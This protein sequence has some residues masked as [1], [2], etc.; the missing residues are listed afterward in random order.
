MQFQSSL[1]ILHYF[2]LASMVLFI[3]FHYFL[4]N[5]D[6]IYYIFSSIVR[7]IN[8]QNLLT[9]FVHFHVFCYFHMRIMQKRLSPGTVFS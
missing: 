5:F 3:H 9:F 7:K 6:K 2:T 4:H 8:N 1:S